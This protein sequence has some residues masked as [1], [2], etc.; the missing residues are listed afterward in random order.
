[1]KGL[2]GAIGLLLGRLFYESGG[3]NHELYRLDA[4]S[5]ASAG[6]E[7][8]WDGLVDEGLGGLGPCVSFGACDA[9]R[10]RH[11]G[12]LLVDLSELAL[13]LYRYIYI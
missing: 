5:C 3:I 13:R 8:G 7:N 2:S 6:L 9:A 10:D 11:G 12:M 1:M 4:S